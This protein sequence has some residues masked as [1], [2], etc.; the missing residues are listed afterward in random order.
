MTR[1]PTPFLPRGVFGLLLI[2]FSHPGFS[3]ENTTWDPAHKPK[4]LVMDPYD[5]LTDE[6][7]SELGAELRK[8]FDRMPYWTVFRQKEMRSTFKKIEGKE[9]LACNS[10]S[11]AH[12][13]GDILQAE[14]TFF[15]TFAVVNDL[16]VFSM[17]CIHTQTA[18]VIWTKVDEVEIT[19]LKHKK[20]Y[21]L[22]HLNNLVRH[23]SPQS[24]YN[25]NLVKAT[26]SIGIINGSP[27]TKY[28][29]PYSTI[30]ADR[31]LFHAHSL[32]SFKV[33]SP[34]EMGFTTEALGVPADRLKQEDI[35]FT[36]ESM[37]TQ[38][39]IHSALVLQKDH[40]DLTLSLYDIQQ[41]NLTR[42]WNYK[43]KSF[44][45][46]LRWEEVFFLNLKREEILKT[47]EE[48]VQKS[49]RW[50]SALGSTVLLAGGVMAI[51]GLN[52]K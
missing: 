17:N 5:L 48:F 10:F 32:K 50:K 23:I 47:Q 6:T 33:I 15:T 20:Y 3:E 1:I 28:S 16:Y 8:S 40:F 43:S 18:Q 14:Y 45:K 21:F 31:L 26:S 38:Y 51:I 44:K 41:K 42:T 34:E 7:D 49:S 35:L 46:I 29:A 30:M 52:Q 2:I 4:V 36:G 13:A 19:A 25:E 39:I 22:Y 12:N 37:G 11:C 9:N 27:T 24:L